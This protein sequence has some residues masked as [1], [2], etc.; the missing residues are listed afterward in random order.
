MTVCSG[1]GKPMKPVPCGRTGLGHRQTAAPPRHWCMV[2]VVPNKLGYASC[3]SDTT[4]HKSAQQF[5]F[6]SHWD[7]WEGSGSGMLPE[8]ALHQG[9]TV[10]ALL[11][12]SFG[13]RILLSCPGGLAFVIPLPQ[14][15]QQHSQACSSF[16]KGLLGRAWA[17]S[18]VFAENARDLG[19]HL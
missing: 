12:F 10:P 6:L 7:L 1:N 4:L 3:L 17:S 13:G 15:S 2:S 8:Q 16:N 19:L 18:T 9:A 5:P 11:C 14:H